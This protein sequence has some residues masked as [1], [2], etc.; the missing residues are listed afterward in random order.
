MSVVEIIQDSS[1]KWTRA[2]P[3][4]EEALHDL[5]AHIGITLPDEYVAFLRMSNGGEG[6]LGVEPG[7]FQIW[8]AEQVIQLNAGY[9]T[10]SFAVGFIG[11]GSNGG[12]EMIA[13]DT[14]GIA[15]WPIVMIPFVGMSP[16]LAEQV[17]TEFKGFLKAMGR[18]LDDV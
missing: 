6:E 18:Q 8:P 9:G 3:A 10:P 7:W 13:F 17:A 11:F 2:A 14:R 1:A 16:E 4:S 5:T 15:P 12:G